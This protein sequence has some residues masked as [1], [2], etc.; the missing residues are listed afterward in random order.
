MFNIKIS[1][2]LPTYN[3]LTGGESVMRV[4]GGNGR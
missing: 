2:Q 4:M 3:F 1:S